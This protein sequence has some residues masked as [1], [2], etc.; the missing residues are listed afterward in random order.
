MG[1][2]DLLTNPPQNFKY[3]VG[4]QG[5]TGNGSTPNMLN[6]RYG[7]DTLGGGDSNQPYI[8]TSIPTGFNGLQNSTSDF[9]L[10]GG[11][12]AAKDSVTDVR[13][14]GKMFKDTKSPNG[15]LFVAKQNLLSR[16]AVRTQAATGPLNEGIYT[17]LSTLA[18]A[19]LV[20]FGGHLNKQGLNPFAGAGSEGYFQGS[21][22]KAIQPQLS[23]AVLNN[24]NL[25]NRLIQLFGIKEVNPSQLQIPTFFRIGN[26]NNISDNN[27][28]I[29]SYTGGPGSI[30]GVGN[31]NIKFASTNLG[32][33]LRTL[34]NPGTQN[35]L[36]NYGNANFLTTGYDGFR[37]LTTPIVSSTAPES[38]TTEPGKQTPGTLTTTNFGLKGV[39]VK[40]S[41]TVKP[42][43]Y[44]N[45]VRNNPNYTAEIGDFRVTLR[46]L[47]NGKSTI[48]SDAPNYSNKNIETRV[49]IGNA[50]TQ[51]G[52]GY[53]GQKNLISYTS[54]SRV[55]PVDR[56][57]AL[58]IYRS[59]AVDTSQPINDLVKF[60]IA[61]IDAQNPTLKNFIHFRAF[62][63]SFSDT[64]N[65]DW[66]TVNY[67]GR[68]ENFYTYKGFNR[69][70]S[71]GW[72]VAAQ[73]KEEI[74]IMYK[75]LNYLASNLAP[76]Y[77]SKGYMAGNLVQLTVGGYLYEQVGF[78]TGLTYDVPTES[79]WEIGINDEGG[80]DSSVKE[81][82][83]IIKVT[84]FNFTPI[85]SFIP[86]KQDLYGF[87]SDDKGI[88][89]IYGD[90]R[91]I[92]LANGIGFEDNNYD[93]DYVEA[94][95]I[96]AKRTGFNTKNAFKTS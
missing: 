20:A 39:P 37:V 22:L 61:A 32:G 66:G 63:D 1:L 90:Q 40:A 57:N 53:K 27:I 35:P 78:I 79:P 70:I 75:K 11:M 65:A 14:L 42:S 67:L 91:F 2:K 76:S 41:A 92:A 10:R 29:L 21:Y 3:Y 50:V 13:R 52:P 19:G 16:V 56:I 8:Q 51:Q 49:N 4:G 62:L 18:E 5:Y 60:R 59:D 26:T 47:L 46:D 69:G 9:I 31:T 96:P 72:T 33:T 30:L 89:T 12:L 58:P 28:N 45:G 80:Y 82:P 94:K 68:G 43:F 83:H 85:Q 23:N 17:P 64:Y 81:V 95:S 24:P 38:G 93:S 36:N 34:Y 7:N 54:G 87:N 6:L 73:S 44:N 71:M 15:L 74:M 88:A 25:S 84:G 55:G 86:S 77:T 48:M